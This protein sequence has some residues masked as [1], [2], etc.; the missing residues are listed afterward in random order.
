MRS[1]PL[2]LFG[3]VTLALALWLPLG[4]TSPVPNV[5]T[6]DSPILTPQPPLV[7]PPTPS[8]S[9]EAE[10]ALRHIAK[11][12]GIPVE[13]LDITADHEWAFPLIGRTFRFVSIM[14]IRT[15]A[16]QVYPVLVDL[17]DGHVEADVNAVVAAE[18]AAYWAKY[19]KFHPSL[20]ERL[21][22]IDDEDSLPI[23]IWL[24]PHPET[25]TQEEVFIE[26]ATRY[27]EAARALEQVGVPWAVDEAALTAQIRE[28]YRQ[29]LAE[30]TA[31]RAGPLVNH[32]SGRGFEVKTYGAMP[33]V[34]AFLPKRVI[35][36][37]AERPDVG[38]IY[39][40]E[41][42]L[43]REMDTAVSTDRVPAVWREGYKG[44][45]VNIAILE[46]GEID[47]SVSCLNIVA[48]RPAPGIGIDE[49]KTMMA[50]VA[51]C[52]HPN[53]TGVAPRAGIIDAGFDYD[54]YWPS[55]GSQENHERDRPIR[56][57]LP[58][59]LLTRHQ[60]LLI[61][62]PDVAAADGSV[63]PVVVNHDLACVFIP[64]LD[65]ELVWGTISG[66]DHELVVVTIGGHITV[67]RACPLELAIGTTLVDH[68]PL[69]AAAVEVQVASRKL[70]LSV[71]S[72]YTCS[73]LV[74]RGK[75]KVGF[76]FSPGAQVAEL[77]PAPV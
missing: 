71:A 37:M 16:G 39:L 29:M 1:K 18:R 32:L 60:P 58:S 44:S 77:A 27:P 28:E 11:R 72:G 76:A 38:M 13:G 14:D 46:S 36:E 15:T 53:Y 62:D 73:F 66:P 2:V 52:D 45:G 54:A 17:R 7:L 4:E 51:A 25:R 24:A 10:I 49:H 75:A 8:P 30:D 5:M 55:G 23:A 41:A 68:Q 56:W 12:E 61:V 20:Y 22:G 69:V 9:E 67:D 26:L 3:M 42:Q 19:G 50:S 33:S 65:P 59:V 57:P 63:E 47:P 35:L 74:L 34:S 40:I 6:F 21:Q 64:D 48:T 70:E 43:S 31:V